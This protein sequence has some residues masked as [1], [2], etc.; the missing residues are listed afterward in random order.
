MILAQPQMRLYQANLLDFLTKKGSLAMQP[1]IK[2]AK[3]KTPTKRHLP[4]LISNG[5]PRAI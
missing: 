5:S 3:T 4:D 1:S 2:A